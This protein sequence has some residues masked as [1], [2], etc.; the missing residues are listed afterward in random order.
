MTEVV[1]GRCIL[2]VR[3]TSG[4]A[5]SGSPDA[6]IQAA[7]CA[8]PALIASRLTAIAEPLAAPVHVTRP[9]RIRIAATTRELAALSEPGATGSATLR[10]RIA[11]EIASAITPAVEHAPR[12]HASDLPVAA[13]EASDLPIA[14]REASERVGGDAEATVLEPELEAPRRAARAWWR[15]GEIAQVLARI[16]DRA[17][18][19]L[20]DMLLGPAPPAMP[21]GSELVTVAERAAARLATSGPVAL[22]PLRVRIA[23]A[24][25]IL[26]ADPGASR[27]RLRVA[28]DHVAAMRD[29]PSTRVDVVA[30]TAA[31][32]EAA[33]TPQPPM[34]P[35]Q[36]AS[37]R[38]RA[39]GGELEIR[40]V[41]PF[42]LL[43]AL[44]HAGWL[45]AATTLL[46]LHDGD[47]AAFAL[48]AGLAAK[49]LDPLERGWVRSR[50]DRAVLAAFA[51]QID[52]IPDARITAAAH[53]LQP[54]LGALDA[55]LRATLARSRKPRPLVLVR[56]DPGDGGEARAWLLI[57]AD[58]MVAIAAGSDLAA[59]LAAAY[60]APMFIPAASADP[61]TLDRIDLANR[62]FITDAAPARGEA[63][64]CFAGTA[65]RLA[66]NDTSTPAARL[67][68]LTAD[69][70]TTIALADELAGVL[71][72]RPAIARDPLAAFD[73]TC[74]LAAT[75][76][77]ADLGARLFPEEPTTPVLALTRF[78]DLD[79]RV[80]FEPDRVVVRVPLGRRHADLMRHGVLGELAHIPWLAGRTVDLGGG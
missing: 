14:A 50:A 71:R 69:M 4:W 37:D 11:H 42:L 68:A 57:D 28:V 77:L 23:I 22:D 45:D 78:R 67:V 73:A 24:A 31:S 36:A 2:R 58:G 26:D 18:S 62:R 21:A 20:H 9:V 49:A 27:T 43:P 66:T 55:S 70:P 29:E 48:A 74:T 19:M 30:H 12:T 79:A 44:H 63:W 5:W 13:R 34:A 6:L 8:L 80:R 40:S 38:A 47:D 32:S 41:L 1:I 3:R 60:D 54:I 72:E 52:P 10:E 39:F 53:R 16:E 75:A 17:A 51:G 61:A 33:V 25:A 65:G 35:S 64:R 7:T 15:S 46:A 76:A 59:I 56:R